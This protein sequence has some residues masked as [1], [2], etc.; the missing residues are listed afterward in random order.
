MQRACESCGRSYE[1]KTKRSRFCQDQRCVRERARGRKR[2]QRHPPATVVELR[3]AK[4]EPLPSSVTAA[5]V[6]EL[7]AAGR[8]GSA[9][10][11][12]ALALARRLDESSAD[13]GSSVASMVKELRATITEAVRSGQGA[14]DPVDELRERR[15]KRLRG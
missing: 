15:S 12:A 6:A 8:V 11:Q 9:L 2:V 3:A 14:A 13:T 4:K 5:T 10:G 1:A 7:D